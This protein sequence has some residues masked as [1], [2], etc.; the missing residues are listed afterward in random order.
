MKTVNFYDYFTTEECEDILEHGYEPYT[1]RIRAAM[2]KAN[3][4]VFNREIGDMEL[5]E[6]DGE[7]TSSD[8]TLSVVVQLA[9]DSD[10]IPPC[11]CRRSIGTVLVFLS[12]S[13]ITV[14]GPFIVGYA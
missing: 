8:G 11:H 9:P 7:W 13:A 4:D 10:Y 12:S 6:I 2:D 14:S 5:A 1:A 3:A